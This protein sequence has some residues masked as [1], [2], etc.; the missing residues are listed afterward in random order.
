MTD[1]IRDGIARRW[2]KL[3]AAFAAGKRTTQ[4]QRRRDRTLVGALRKC[5]ECGHYECPCC[6]DWCD[7]IVDDEM[8]CDGECS[9]DLPP[10]QRVDS[11]IL[12]SKQNTV[13][14]LRNGNL[15]IPLE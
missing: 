8:C 14:T 7:K 13:V 1:K 12:N 11:F 15:R 2:S 5:V 9:F 3:S 4:S 10:D 6:R